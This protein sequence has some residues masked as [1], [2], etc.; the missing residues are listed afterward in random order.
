MLVLSSLNEVNVN[1]MIILPSV[2]II[3]QE[4]TTKQCLIS[5][6]LCIKHAA[7]QKLQPTEETTRR[8]SQEGGRVLPS[9]R[10]E[11]AKLS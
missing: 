1:S 3:A 2:W 10:A 4:D 7:A 6:H 9:C 8:G 11:I 5:G